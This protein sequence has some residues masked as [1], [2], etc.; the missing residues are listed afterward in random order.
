MS[1]CWMLERVSKCF[2][3]SSTG[4]TGMIFVLNVHFLAHGLCFNLHMYNT[5]D[6]TVIANSGEI[7]EAPP[8]RDFL[9][10]LCN[11]SFFV[12]LLLPDDIF[13]HFRR[14]ISKLHSI[15][16]EQGVFCVLF[17]PVSPFS[18]KI[19]PNLLASFSHNV[20]AF[21][22]VFTNVQFNRNAGKY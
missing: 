4:T 21:G 13:S 17:S 2:C 5:S 9:G 20:K 14:N 22:S 3:L 10:S 11:C 18:R 8:R 12:F 6:K 7:T 19:I 1:F 16:S 15:S